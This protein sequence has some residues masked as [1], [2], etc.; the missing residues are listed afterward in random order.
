VQLEDLEPKQQEEHRTPVFVLGHSQS[1]V[2]SIAWNAMFTKS[3][4]TIISHPRFL[5]RY[6]LSA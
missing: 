1:G 5:S 3:V 6:S 4:A 2:L